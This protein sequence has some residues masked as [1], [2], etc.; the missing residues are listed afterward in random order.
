[1]ECVTVDLRKGTRDKSAKWKS[2][3]RQWCYTEV[4]SHGGHDL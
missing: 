4:L 3:N 2:E 1:M